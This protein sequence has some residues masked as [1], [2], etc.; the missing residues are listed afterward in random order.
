VRRIQRHIIRKTEAILRQKPSD[1]LDIDLAL[2]G[3]KA[4]DYFHFRGQDSRYFPDVFRKLDMPVAQEVGNAIIKDFVDHKV[5]EVLVIYNLFK[6]AVAQTITVQRILPVTTADERRIEGGGDV[7]YEPSA[8]KLL[9]HLLPRYVY[10]QLYRALLE[11]FAS[12]MGARMTAMENAS[13]NAEELIKV[14]TLQRNRARQAAITKELVEISTG[15]EV[16]KG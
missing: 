7:I 9:D 8:D 12:E 1:Y 5:D 15:V 13:N 10:V 11:S 14:L 6:S 3:R 4:N 16:L 2:I